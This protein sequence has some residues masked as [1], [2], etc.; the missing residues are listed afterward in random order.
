MGFHYSDETEGWIGFVEWKLSAV[1]VSELAL[2][3]L[4]CVTGFDC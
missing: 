1:R 4:E 2:G 3:G